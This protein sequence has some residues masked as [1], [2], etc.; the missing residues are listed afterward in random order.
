MTI[1]IDLNRFIKWQMAGDVSE[2]TLKEIVEDSWRHGAFS[3]PLRIRTASDYFAEFGY[4]SREIVD[5]W[6][7]V[8]LKT[9]EEGKITAEDINDLYKERIKWI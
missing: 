9:K 4:I 5:N 6:N 8:N 3:L 2:E 1:R 7:E